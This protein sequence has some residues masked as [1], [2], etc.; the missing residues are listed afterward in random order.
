MALYYD[1]G[2]NN[3]LLMLTISLGGV[4]KCGVGAGWCLG[5]GEASGV[6]RVVSSRLVIVPEA[7]VARDRRRR[8]TSS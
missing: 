6:S 7:S 5:V 4:V 3:G 8:W 1:S 2:S